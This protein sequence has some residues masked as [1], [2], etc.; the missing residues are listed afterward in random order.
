[1]VLPIVIYGS[2][3]LRQVA[4]P[5]EAL[6]PEIEQLIADMWDTMYNAEGVGLAAPQVGRSLRLFVAD[7]RN[8][9]GRDLPDGTKEDLSSFKHVFI[10][11]KIEEQ[12]DQP[13][14]FNEGCLSI[15]GIRENVYRHEW[16]RIR[17]RDEHWNEHVREFSG[18][19]ARV[20]QHE[21]DHI[22]GVLF[23]DKISGLRKQL[24]R[25]KL[26]RMTRGEVNAAYPV[27]PHDRKKAATGGG[28]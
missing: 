10:N 25:N 5:I 13:W 21:Y 12:W 3:V 11:A 23:V 28:K 16:I 2:P 15:P 27:L 22:E 26:N 9:E 4:Q 14:P 1:M 19:Q 7:G 24:I 17:Y 8:M 18:I 20:I 6:T